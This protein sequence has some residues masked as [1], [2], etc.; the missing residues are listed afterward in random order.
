M[1]F[2]QLLH[3]HTRPSSAAGAVDQLATGLRSGRSLNPLQE[4]KKLKKKSGD[5]ICELIY[6]VIFTV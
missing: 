1:L 3:T 5:V 6:L 2:H 4:K